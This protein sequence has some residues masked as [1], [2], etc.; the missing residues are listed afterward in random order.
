MHCPIVTLPVKTVWSRFGF[1]AALVVGIN[2][3]VEV[4]NLGFSLAQTARVEGF[5]G[6]NSVCNQIYYAAEGKNSPG[7]LIH[8]ACNILSFLYCN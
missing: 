8:S 6:L 4:F 3:L 1:I 2:N 7:K 5:I